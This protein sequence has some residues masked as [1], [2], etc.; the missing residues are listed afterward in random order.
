MTNRDYVMGLD[1]EKLA[2]LMWSKKEEICDSISMKTCC[3]NNCLECIKKWLEAERNPRV[4]RGQM[5]RNPYD[6]YFW[7][8]LYVGKENGTHNWCLGLDEHGNVARLSIDV[9]CTWLLWDIDKEKNADDVNKF[10]E[11]LLNYLI[12]KTTMKGNKIKGDN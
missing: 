7:V 2:K 11:R 5:R 6:G 3:Y 8:I 9:V 12:N 10:L 1:N 4:E